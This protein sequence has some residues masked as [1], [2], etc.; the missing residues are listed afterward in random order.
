MQS[1]ARWHQRDEGADAEQKIRALAQSARVCSR[2]HAG[3]RMLAA[4]H[5]HTG[6]HLQRSAYLELLARH[7]MPVHDTSE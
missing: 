1:R 2:I 3:V 5:A 4:R 7:Y 6:M